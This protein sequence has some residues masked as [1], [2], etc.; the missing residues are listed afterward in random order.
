MGRQEGIHYLLEAARHI[1][2]DLGRTDVQ[3]GLVGGGSELEAMKRLAA[4]LDVAD[5]VT[6][7]GRAPDAEMLAMLNTADVCVNPEEHNEMND[8][9]TM[10]S[11]ERRGGKECVS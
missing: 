1:V 7:T 2:H 5:Y 4:D 10:R 6:F 8:K 9:S 11:E 3:F